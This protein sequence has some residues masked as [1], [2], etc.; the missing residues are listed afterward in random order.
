MAT[1]TSGLCLEETKNIRIIFIHLLFVLECEPMKPLLMHWWPNNNMGSLQYCAR[2]KVS[3][4]C[5]PDFY[6]FLYYDFLLKVKY[7]EM[8]VCQLIPWVYSLCLNIAPRIS[9]TLEKSRF[10]NLWCVKQA[11]SRWKMVGAGFHCIAKLHA[12]MPQFATIRIT[13]WQSALNSSSSSKTYI[14]V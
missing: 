2:S 8:C 4:Q 7:H 14:S 11:V 13:A 5:L 6:V 10:K 1:R 3:I 12:P 9:F